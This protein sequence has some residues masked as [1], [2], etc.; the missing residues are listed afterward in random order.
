MNLNYW[1]RLSRFSDIIYEPKQHLLFAGLWFLSL[2][3]L[4]VLLSTAAVWHWSLSTVG[5]IL[6]L[7]GVLFVLRAIDEVKDLEYDQQYNPDRPLVSGVVSVTDIRSYVLFATLI[8]ATANS[9]IALPLSLFIAVNVGYGLLL[10]WL[11]KTMPL[12]DKSL[13]F[14]LIITYPVSIALSFYTLLQTQHS[15]HT[16][17]ST[18]MLLTIG[19][20]VLAFLHFEIIRKSMWEHLSDPEEKLYSG[21]IGCKQAL[22]VASL[23]GAGAVAGILLLFKP[24]NLT[25]FAA[26]TGWLPL[27]NLIFI[28]LSL[29]LFVTNRSQRFNPRKF[30]VPYIVCFYSLNLIHGLTWNQHSI[31]HF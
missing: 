6:T 19:C 18:G 16:T 24:W 15:Q 31:G 25:G 14:N 4:F 11:E 29:R 30:S 21:E 5:S 13:F 3:G 22:L 27:I 20:Y 9:F 8:V 23:F 17:I 2:Q 26:V 1:Q 10:M 28:V 12:M 7:F